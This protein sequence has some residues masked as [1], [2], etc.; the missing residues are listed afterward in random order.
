MLVHGLSGSFRWWSRNL[1]ALSQ[2]FEVHAIDLPGFGGNRG[3]FTLDAA[4]AQLIAWMDAREMT[5]ASLIGHSMGGFIAADLAARAPERVERLVLADAPLLPSGRG[6]PGLAAAGARSG[7]RLPLPFL[8][9]LVA[10]ALRAGPF[11]LRRAGHALLSADLTPRLSRIAAPTLVIW[12]ERDRFFS[13]DYGRRVA[14]ALPN[15]AF[16][17][18]PGAGHNVMWDQPAAFNRAVLDFLA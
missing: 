1:E 10:D 6:L 16:V 11:T 17:A 13:V 14:E 8:P 12:G 7:W 15:A 2:R 9:V 18:I 3:R 5:R 4:A